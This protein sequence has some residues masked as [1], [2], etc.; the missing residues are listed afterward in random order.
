MKN[1]QYNFGERKRTDVRGIKNN[2]MSRGRFPVA[3]DIFFNER[4]F[5]VIEADERISKGN[6]VS[7]EG[8]SIDDLIIEK[9]IIA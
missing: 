6:Y 7:R 9:N 8:R 3:N 2:E 4:M 5:G 1:S